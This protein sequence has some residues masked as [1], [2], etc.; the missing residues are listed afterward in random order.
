MLTREPV[1]RLSDLYR[2]QVLALDVLNEGD[3]HELVVGIVLDD[4]GNLCETGELGRAPPAF[5]GDELI[6]RTGEADD[7]WLDDAMLSD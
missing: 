6:T 7:Q 2:V 4:H 5:P 3:L 1:E